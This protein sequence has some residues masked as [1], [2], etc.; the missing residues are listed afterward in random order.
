MKTAV[1]LLAGAILALAATGARASDLMPS[2]AS[3]PAGW[4]VDRYAPASFGNVGA[5]QGQ[6]NVL[7]IGI[8]P[9]ES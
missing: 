1:S 5:Y 3:T 4:T 8:A 9:V 7:G 2:F 6:W